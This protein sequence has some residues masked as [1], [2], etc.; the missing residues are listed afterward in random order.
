M[1]KVKLTFLSVMI[2]FFLTAHAP[3][4][5][6]NKVK[7]IAIEDVVTNLK[8]QKRPVLI[9]LYTDWCGWCKVMDKKTYSNENV[10]AYLGDKFYAVRLN[11]E[12]KKEIIWDGKSYN[13]N[14]SYRANEFSVY[15]TKG[16]L[17]FPTTII[18]PPD[19]GE[20]QAIAGYLETKDFELIAK[21]FGEGI[22][23]KF[24]FEDY[25]KNFK[26]SW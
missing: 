20:P 8:I 11:A 21:Y 23:N 24:S 19:G 10:A 7:W 25:Q 13:Y 1:Q 4:R 18:I 5:A 14:S 9:D 15:I 3:V 2:F 22:Y 16:R 12:T 6:F 17:E 26:S